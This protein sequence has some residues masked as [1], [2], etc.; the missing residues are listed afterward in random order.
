MNNQFYWLSLTNIFFTA[1][2]KIVEA[3]SCFSYL[4]FELHF[5]VSDTKVTLM[6]EAVAISVVLYTICNS[7]CHVVVLMELIW[8][9]IKANAEFTIL[10]VVFPCMLVITQLL[11]QLNALVFY[12]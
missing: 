12:Y 3:L 2:C 11:F 4:F 10:I 5:I 6:S 9:L 1:T 8:K 7:R